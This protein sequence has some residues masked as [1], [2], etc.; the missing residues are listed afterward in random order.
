MWE[1]GG[2]AGGLEG[3]AAPYPHTGVGN[4]ALG[5]VGLL[6]GSKPLLYQRLLTWLQ[7]DHS[8]SLDLSFLI[9]K[10]GIT[11]VPLA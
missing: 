6:P 10:M 8:A 4:L 9:C 11:E 2:T 7:A 5:T 1:G 3:R